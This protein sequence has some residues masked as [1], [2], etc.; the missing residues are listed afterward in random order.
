MALR[1]IIYTSQASKPLSKRGLLDML[2]ES[3]A[4]NSIDNISGVLMHRKGTF[5]QVIEGNPEDVEDLFTRIQRDSRHK[6]VKIILD[7]S[8]DSRHFSNWAMGC[9]DFDEPELSLIPGI[10]TDLSDPQVIE[11]IITRL[12]EIANFLLEKLD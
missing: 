7:S 12:P 9:A 4:F 5:I 2:H 10:R 11:D 8:V 3:R 6:E 1:R